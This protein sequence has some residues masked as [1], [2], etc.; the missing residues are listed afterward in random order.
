MLGLESCL[1]YSNTSKRS[2]PHPRAP[3]AMRL[4][5]VLFL[6]VWFW[7]WYESHIV[8]IALVLDGNGKIKNP[9]VCNIELPPLGLFLLSTLLPL[10]NFHYHTILGFGSTEMAHG[11][12]QR[13]S[14]KPPISAPQR[15]S[16]YTKSMASDLTTSYQCTLPIIFTPM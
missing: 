7:S 12:H 5:D 3:N 8:A 10:Y 4:G 2:T 14:S 1:K 13:N 16:H 11:R 15:Y 6:R 9:P